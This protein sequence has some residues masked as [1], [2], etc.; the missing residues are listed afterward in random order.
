MFNR[1]D[2]DNFSRINDETFPAVLIEGE[3]KLDK[4]ISICPNHNVCIQAG[5]NFGIFPHYLSKHFKKV[6]TLEPCDEIMV[7]AKKNIANIQNIE[8]IHAALHSLKGSCSINFDDKNCGASSVTITSDEGVPTVTVDS[9]SN[10][11]QGCD[12][13]YLDIEGAEY[14]AMLGSKETMEKYKPI[15]VLENKGLIPNFNSNIH[16]SNKFREYIQ[17]TFNYKYH[18]RLMRDD[19]YVAN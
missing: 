7:H 6:I 5:C 17:K 18:G 12:L 19:I 13:L 1:K 14:E 4:I 3:Q 8:L 2:Y 10:L 15:L 11:Y 16:G 9:L